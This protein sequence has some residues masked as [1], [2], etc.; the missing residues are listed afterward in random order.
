MCGIAG[1]IGDFNINANVVKQFQGHRGP[2]HFGYY[3]NDED[4]VLLC[5]NRLSI[6]DLSSQANQPMWD[7]QNRFCILFNGEV[8]NFPELRDELSSYKFYT[9]S[10]TE[11][12]LAA[13]IRWGKE[14]LNKFTGMF[15]FVI[16][17]NVTKELFGARDRF[18]VKPFHYNIT[19][20]GF[21]FASEIKTL[22]AMGVPVFENERSWS[23]YLSSGMYD[24]CNQTFWSDVNRL[25]PGCYFI[26]SR[27]TGLQQSRWYDVSAN[28]LERGIDYRDEEVIKDELHELLLDSVRLRF[29]ADVPVGVLV[30]GGLDSSLLYGIIKKV[31]NT[32]NNLKSFT[33]YTADEKYDERPWVYQL[34]G[35]KG[36]NNF[37]EELN[38]IDIL[39]LNKLNYYHQE[40]PFGGFPTLAFSLLHKKANSENVTVLLDG[41]G[42]DEG[43][44]GYDYYENASKYDLS[45][46]PVQST[47][48]SFSLASSLQFDFASNGIPLEFN[49]SIYDSATKL[50]IRDLC[51]AKIPRAM[52]FA[53]RVS[54]IYSR[55]LR[56]PFLDHR[57]IEL[58]LRQPIQN[59]I[60]NGVRK[61]LVREVGKRFINQEVSSAI[62]RPVQTP[63]RE[64][65][66]NELSNWVNDCMDEIE[67][68]PYRY[69]FD[70]KSLHNIWNKY[71]NESI[72][73][74]FPIWQIISLSSMIQYK[75]TIQ[76]KLT[77]K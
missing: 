6:I 27:A 45:K 56:E 75:S 70:M 48:Q 65:L 71:R 17:D 1:F 11:V 20:K 28:V 58:G 19:S 14:C 53:D 59:K 51:F 33:F 36:A 7:H 22:F 64:W 23:T 63:Q 26:Y 68:S 67:Q 46:G 25:N 57:I 37:F 69:W 62:K 18:G 34:L 5:H 13:F 30:S 42:I 41:N 31:L 52:R 54:M 16:W 39:N 40:E 55:E 74:S 21:R 77:S 24:H 15:S 44:G 2:D 12:V 32:T 73:N 61:Y 29:R 3:R 72:N 43:W 49:S 47:D 9:S 8:Y 35:N 4:S 50:Q 38:P 66:K 76:S 60:R 10:D